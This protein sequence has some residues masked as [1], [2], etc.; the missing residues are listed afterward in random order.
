MKQSSLIVNVKFLL[1]YIIM[2][3]YKRNWHSENRNS[4]NEFFKE[5]CY[6]TR[7]TY[8]GSNLKLVILSHIDDSNDNIH[9]I[10]LIF[11]YDL[12]RLQLMKE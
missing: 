8:Y 11:L 9:A 3:K 2:F 7:F 5:K 10:L 1:D 12:L 4:G 6:I